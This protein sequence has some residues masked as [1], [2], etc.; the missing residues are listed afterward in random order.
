MGNLLKRHIMFYLIPFIILRLFCILIFSIGI[1]SLKS[2]YI[3][4]LFIILDISCISR[5]IY[6]IVKNIYNIRN[7]NIEDYQK[8]EQ[9][10]RNPLLI[11]RNNYIL[12]DTYI[13]NLRTSHL[14]EYKD[15]AY[16]YKIVG[17][18][19]VTNIKLGLVRCLCTITKDKR[20]D[21]FII[22]YLGLS[23]MR[24]EDFSR[25]IMER[26]NNIKYKEK[27]II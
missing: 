8:I 26:N 21:K 13:V 9:E 25:L 3:L 4:V 24:F 12:T 18:G 5:L 2:N 7:T 6:I 15:I 1:I 10:L 22:S 19:F 14:F 17:I 16:I 27:G 23:N 20:I 11:V